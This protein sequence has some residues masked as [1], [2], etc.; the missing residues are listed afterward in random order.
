MYTIREVNQ[1]MIFFIHQRLMNKNVTETQK[2]QLQKHVIHQ[3][4]YR[5]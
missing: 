2:T 1:L 4:S 3:L 5:K